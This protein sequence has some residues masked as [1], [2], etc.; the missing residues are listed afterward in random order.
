MAD[1]TK[2]KRIYSKQMKVMIGVVAAISIVF[3]LIIGL[4]VESKPSKK[5]NKEAVDLVGVINESFTEKN[6]ESAL[7]AQ[8]IE[9][10]GLKEQ[11]AHMSK[12]F[13]SINDAKSKENNLLADKVKA[14]SEQI[15]YLKEEKKEAKAPTQ[16]LKNPTLWH[17]NNDKGTYQPV[18]FQNP[19]K[20]SMKL[21]SFDGYY[22]SQ[23][24]KK[25][26]Y[27]PSNTSVRAVLLGGADSDASVNGQQE[28][29]SAML[30]KF[31]DDGTMPNGAKSFLKG[32]RVSASSYGDISSERAYV[33]LYKL[34]CAKKGEPIIDKKV[35]GWVFFGGKVGIKGVPLMR[36]GKVVTWAGV[37]GAL[38]GISQ[39]AQA[40]QS[41]QNITPIGATS[42]LPSD[43]VAG[44]AGFGGA[45]KAAEQLSSYYIK[46]AEQYHP[47][48][49][50]GAGNVATI[51]F[52]DGF[53]LEP[54]EDRQYSS[55]KASH[56]ASHDYLSSANNNKDEEFSVENYSVPPEVLSHIN[57]VQQ[58]RAKRQEG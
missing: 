55:E 56:P 28:N 46:R 40:A 20:N 22:K 10:E 32:C 25:R 24:V 3:A 17:A 53:Y 19:A 47:V 41:I 9:L 57:K 1:F 36:D 14:L 35:N 29:N 58:N 13:D 26:R 27:V 34:S 54:E 38:S 8:Q 48:I 43:R 42:I 6:T 37:S 7:S 15:T 45:S 50:V 33:A 4:L 2:N 39:A 12:K 30:F 51:V 18:V 31:L 5:T 44:F 49:Q 16:E 23:V 21:V 11:L 52:K